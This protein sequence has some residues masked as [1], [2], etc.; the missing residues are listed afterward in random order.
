MVF[1][2][3]ELYYHNK[4]VDVRPDYNTGKVSV[5]AN[6]RWIP[7]EEAIPA[8]IKNYK[9]LKVSSKTWLLEYRGLSL[10]IYKERIMINRGDIWKYIDLES[11]LPEL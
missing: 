11:E 2:Y 9:S 10:V 5:T 3:G 7:P 8:L 1:K 4:V 6:G